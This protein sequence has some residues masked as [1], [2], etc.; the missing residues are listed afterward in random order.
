VSETAV[1]GIAGM[2]ASLVG[3]V[4]GFG[5]QQTAESRR[6]VRE[7]CSV[8]AALALEA[9]EH[10]VMA[11]NAR[12]GGPPP[13]P[14]R[15]EFK[16][17]STSVIAR[18]ALGGPDK[19]ARAALALGQAVQSA[20]AAQASA[21]EGE[22]EQGLQGVVSAMHTF[23]EVVRR[24]TAPVWRRWRRSAEKDESPDPQAPDSR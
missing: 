13:D 2:I 16:R 10:M 23:D 17:E 20:I 14:L 18:L 24:E 5:L 22:R 6:Y 4:I 9:L 21:V 19:V 3:V 8:L 11:E 7:A 15:P 1:L 12:N